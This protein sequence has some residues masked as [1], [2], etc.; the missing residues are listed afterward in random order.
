MGEEATRSLAVRLNATSG[1]P[2]KTSLKV[3][4]RDFRKAINANFSFGSS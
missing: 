3:I 4:Q 1:I 2:M